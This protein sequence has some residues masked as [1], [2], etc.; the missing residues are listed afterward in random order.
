MDVGE[1][2]APGA[3]Q[4]E[5]LAE[6]RGFE[7]CNGDEVELL[8]QTRRRDL[9]SLST[10]EGKA[11]PE[12]RHQTEVG[13]QGSRWWTGTGQDEDYV[14]RPP[15]SFTLAQVPKVRLECRRRMEG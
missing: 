9:D 12:T 10:P 5:Q 7:P 6:C 14:E 3:E 8:N 1:V 11:R 4:D 2:Q 15:L 13:S